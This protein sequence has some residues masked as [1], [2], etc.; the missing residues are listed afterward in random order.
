MSSRPNSAFDPPT[1]PATL[2]AI[3]GHVR[4]PDRLPIAGAQVCAHL[5]GSG[6]QASDGWAPACVTS[7]RDGAY[8]IDGL[9]PGPRR[10][11]AGAANRIPATYRKE[12]GGE[13]VRV[14]AGREARDIDLVLWPGGVEL[15]GVVRDV[16]GGEIEGAVVR[17]AAATAFSGADGRFSMFVRPGL[18]YVQARAEGYAPATINASAPGQTVELALFP[19]SVLVGR[20]VRAEDGLPIA[21]AEVSAGDRGAITTHTDASG[22]FRLGGLRAGVYKPRAVSDEAWGLAETGVPLALGETSAPVTIRA[23]PAVTVRGKI[24][25]DE[26]GSCETGRVTLTDPATRR[27]VSGAVEADGEVA[28]RGLSPG[29]Y[30]ATVWCFGHVPEDNYPAVAVAEAAVAGLVWRVHAGRRITG[31]LV[32]SGGASVTMAAG[33]RARLEGGDPHDF[34]SQ[35]AAVVQPDG[36]FAL[37]G[38]RPGRYSLTA[39]REG[40]A[41]SKPLTVDAGE[42][43][44]ADVELVLPAGG[45]VRGRLLDAQGRPVRQAFV[46][47]AGD[48]QTGWG[49][50]VAD[51][52]SFTL[53]DV[54]E[55]AY[56]AHASDRRGPLRVSGRGPDDLPGVPV[57]VKV[58]AVAQLEFVVEAGGGEI[59]GKVVDEA[60]GPVTDAQVACALESDRPGA[61]SALTRAGT[62][63]HERPTLTDQDGRFVL[64]DLSSGTYAVRAWSGGGAT[65]A[66]AERVAPGSE[67]VLTMPAAGEIGGSVRL[68][69]GGAPEWLK[70]TAEEPTLDYFR[71]DQSFKTGG[72]FALTGLPPGTYTVRAEAGE[73]SAETKVTL[74]AGEVQRGVELVLAPRIELRGRVIDLETGEPLAGVRVEVGIGGQHGLTDANGRFAIAGTPVG[75]VSLRLS[76]ALTDPQGPGHTN[77]S[78][79]ILVEGTDAMELPPIALVRRRL[80]PGTGPGD[81]GYSLQEPPTGEDPRLRRW[82]VSAVRAGGPAASV[83]L[84]L[85][86]EIVA[87]DG[88]PVAGPDSYR[89]RALAL[90]TS[91]R[92]VQLGLARGDTLAVTA[93]PLR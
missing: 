32:D 41:S 63:S 17:F 39:S 82:L 48:R 3:A 58:G 52:G 88:H 62:S 25:T 61:R 8:R 81:L 24:V 72:R 60:G 67:L 93:V 30:E 89:Y 53:R 16:S 55:G 21:G 64:T 49:G 1:R 33:L 65:Q 20:V 31:R 46:T 26:G 73:G 2:G 44:V 86:D 23:H 7:S 43:D 35:G 34:A 54:P 85:G 27:A 5:A 29:S 18:D 9:L 12:D 22:Q 78:V 4:G 91:G 11:E 47:L 45:E 71:H 80:P 66:T 69:V 74:A 75:A 83:G 14:V 56:R 28:V 10:V 13:S 38:L 70:V 76:P 59:R 50:A 68:A 19:E 92:T 51:D 79:P 42:R 36:S 15:R 77:T 40:G 87:I 84:R 57:E 90:V 6:P 37:L